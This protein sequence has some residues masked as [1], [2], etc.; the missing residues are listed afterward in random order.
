M[1]A[2]TQLKS[3]E[4]PKRWEFLEQSA[5][6]EGI[7]PAQFVER[8]D[9]AASRIDRLLYKVR[10]AGGGGLFEVFFGLS[11]AGK[12][13][14]LK[15]LPKFFEGVS[16]YSFT[17]DNS[18]SQIANFVESK[19]VPRESNVRIVLI[20]QRDNPRG[21]DL[22][23]AEEALAELLDV[24]RTPA[25]KALVLWPITNRDSA[26]KVAKSAWEIGRD[27]ITDSET[28]G[29]YT[30]QGVPKERFYPLADE[31]SRNLTGDGLAAFGVTDEI[32]ER[33][34]AESETIGAFFSSISEIADKQNSDTLTALKQRLGV[35][36]WVLLPGDRVTSLNSTVSALTQ[37]T[38]GRID[39]DKIGELWISPKTKQITF[40]SGENVDLSWLTSS[41]P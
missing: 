16:V 27:S 15:T 7:D 13:T 4:L 37:G 11:G 10:R 36:L 21:S 29:F 23:L 2:P 12:T 8:V 32:A 3:L 25:G 38:K 26:E 6:R 19:F 24:F 17:R 28:R 18:I 30:F 20:E 5:R 1:T 34:L 22:D 33:N 31:T 14:F 39:L 35:R 40:L 9:T 41:E